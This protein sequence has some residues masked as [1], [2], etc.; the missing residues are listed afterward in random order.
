MRNVRL[1]IGSG[2]VYLLNWHNVDVAGPNTYLAKDRPDLVEKWATTEEHGYYA[3]HQDKTQDKLRSGPLDQEYVCDDYADFLCLRVDPIRHRLIEVLSRHSFE[4]LSINEAK[5]ALRRI[6][7]LMDPA[8]LL[9]ID[10]PDHEGTMRAFRETGDEFYI[11]HLLG[12]R[13]NQYGFHMMSYTREALRELVESI[14]FEYVEEEKNIHF[15]PAF[16]LKFRKPASV[17]GPKAPAP[18]DYVELPGIH[19]DE[20]FIDVGPGTH[21]HP[22]AD[23]CLDNDPQVI[24]A[25]SVPG[26]KLVLSNIEDGL[27]S[28]PNKAYDYVWC[29]HVLEHLEDPEKA[30]A[31]LS[32]IGKRGTVVLPSVFKD[33]LMGFEEEG[34]KWLVL[35]N[36]SNGQPPIFVRKNPD[37]MKRITSPDLQRAAC[38][39][40]RTGSDHDCTVER[41]LHG[42]FAKNEVNLDVV[43]H[44]EGEFKVQVIR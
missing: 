33:S 42:W 4:H 11:R 29:S 15:Y 41:N 14:G 21:P 35:P 34:H 30:A 19:S 1:H 38:F 22:R 6:F 8:G 13:R 17:P 12:P 44:W 16:C 2:S 18:C 27:R 37:Y 26:K 31:T 3:R 25:L 28:I 23:V 24:A 10:V 43:I 20:K 7:R 5:T 32:R 9:R 36:P 39:L 40:F